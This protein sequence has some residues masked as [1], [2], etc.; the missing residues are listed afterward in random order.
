MASVLSAQHKNR[1]IPKFWDADYN[2]VSEKFSEAK[3]INDYLTLVKA[4]LLHYNILLFNLRACYDTKIQKQF[5]GIEKKEKQEP[6]KSKE[7]KETQKQEVDEEGRGRKRSERG[8][9]GVW[10]FDL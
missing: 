8:G 1:F 7:K 9:E 6:E 5:Q 10:V 2:K 4:D 3:S